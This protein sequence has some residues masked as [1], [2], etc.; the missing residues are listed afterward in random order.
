MPA[1]IL[2]SDGSSL[3]T[4]DGNLTTL[5]VGSG[6]SGSYSE[7]AE[8]DALFNHISGFYQLSN[9]HVIISDY[10]N[11]CLRLVDR[12][13]NE[14]LHYS[15]ICATSGYRDGGSDLALYSN[16][17]DITR[18]I[19]ILTRLFVADL[20]NNAIRELNTVLVVVKTFFKGDDRFYPSC[21]AQHSVTGDLYITSSSQ[22]FFL[23]YKDKSLTLL[24]GSQSQTGF[25]DGPFAES[26]FNYPKDILLNN[27]HQLVIADNL[28]NRL[29]IM[30]LQEKTTSSVCS[31]RTG[32]S[33][34]SLKDCT[35]YHPSSLM[36]AY[37]DLYVGERGRI[38]RIQGE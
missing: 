31:G 36:I 1:N 9:I 15:G 10:H 33:D 25:N 16:P 30:D 26:L 12:V 38:R 34:G 11:H 35:L 6:K 23:T 7:G 8:S 20:S 21:I 28:N 24:A 17:Y 27:D 5:I 32:H 4:S 22:I 14:T 13:S 29:R 3:K 19:K 37:N 2:F 18:D